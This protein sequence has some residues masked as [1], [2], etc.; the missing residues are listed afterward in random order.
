MFG[1]LRF[2]ERMCLC[3]LRRDVCVSSAA[4]NHVCVNTA[5]R[6]ELMCVDGVGEMIADALLLERVAARGAFASREDVRLRLLEHLLSSAL[7]H[8]SC[9]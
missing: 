8:F 1:T 3:S 4:A 9:A 5:T 2:V 6:E 7:E